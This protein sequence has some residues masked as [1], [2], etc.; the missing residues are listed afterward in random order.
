MAKFI[1]KSSSEAV[2][3]E[4]P[5]T[6]KQN[7]KNSPKKSKNQKILKIVGIVVAAIVIF[8]IVTSVV[9]NT[10][11]KDAIKVSDRFISDIQ[12]KDANDAYSLVN[13]GFQ[14]VTT[15]DQFTDVVNRIAPI[16]TGKPSISGKSINKTT[17][18]D[19]AVIVVYK[20]DGSDSKTYY[21]RVLLVKKNGEWKIQNM[22]SDD[23]P[24]DATSAE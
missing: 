13:D 17:G 20:I 5:A 14:S 19:A 3:S 2:D 16:L 4:Q 18:S 15:K 6:D 11:T 7:S 23:K 1:K 21:V 22:R 24:I 10:T 9:V 12:S 8:V